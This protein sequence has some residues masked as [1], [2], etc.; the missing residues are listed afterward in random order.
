MRK[1][2]GQS[3]APCS[4][5]RLS[6]PRHGE[7]VEGRGGLGREQRSHGVPRQ[8]GQLDGN[9]IDA[10]RA[11]LVERGQIVAAVVVAAR[12]GS[13]RSRIALLR[14]S[15]S[16]PRVSPG[17]A[18]SSL[19]GWQR[20]EFALQIADAQRVPVDRCGSQWNGVPDAAER[21]LPSG[22][23]IASSTSAQ[24]STE[25]QMG[26][27]L[28]IVQ[29]SA[30]APVRGTKPKVGRRPVAPQRVEGERDGAQ[31][32]RADG[33]AH[34][35]RGDGAGRACRRSARSLRGIPRIARAPAEPLV[36]HGQRAERELGD[37]HGA[38]RIEPLDHGCVFIEGLML[39]SA[40]APRGRIAFDGEQIFRAPGNAVQRAAIFARGDFFVGGSW[41]ARAR[42]L[43]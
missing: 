40:R 3:S 28:S 41:P 19:S 37:E 18:S 35:A 20:I 33:E 4:V 24:S 16:L 17:L 26:P 43:R 1:A 10:H 14:A 30:M 27:S 29:L 7:V 31:R 2:L 25:R 8:L 38:G 12:A 34:A 42:A 11:Q 39:E 13:L 21:S 36:A 22:P 6:R 5:S 32:L 15:S 23:W 9:E